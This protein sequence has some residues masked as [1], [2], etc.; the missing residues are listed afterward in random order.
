MGVANI[1]SHQ[2]YDDANLLWVFDDEVFETETGARERDGYVAWPPRGFVPRE[3]VYDRWSFSI[4]GADFSEAIVTVTTGGEEVPLSPLTTEG[5][6][7]RVPNPIVVWEL[8]LQGSSE[9]AVYDVEISDVSLGGETRDYRYSVSV[10][11]PLLDQ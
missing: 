6:P 5:R 4:A 1:E 2:G 11:A 9:P 3:I 7:G 10:L 8:D